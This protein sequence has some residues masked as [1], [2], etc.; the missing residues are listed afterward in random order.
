MRQYPDSPFADLAREHLHSCREN[1]AQQE[2]LIAGYYA[3]RRHLRAA[4]YRLI[5]LVNQYP[6]TDTAAEG[7]VQLG[8]IYLRQGRQDL[9][10]LA[11]SAVAYH[12][13]DNPLVAEAERQLNRLAAANQ[14]GDPLVLLKAQT[15]RTRSF[16]IAPQVSRGIDLAR[17]AK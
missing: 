8:K 9:A 4:E 7:L 14:A 17:D 3:K 15:G 10:A 13:P 2:L 12:H 16:A 5:D 11:F 6:E 1:L